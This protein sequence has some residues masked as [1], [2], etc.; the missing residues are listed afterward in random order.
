MHW[1]IYDTH[2]RHTRFEVKIILTVPVRPSKPV[3]SLSSP[4]VEGSPLT[5]TCVSTGGYPKQDVS[6]YRESVSPGNRLG[7]SVSFVNNTLYDVTSTL[8][9]TPTNQDDGVTYICQSSYNDD[10][11]LIQTSQH[12]ILLLCKF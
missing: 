11:R 10:S 6:W 9:F 2:K 3:I 8:M 4:A 7:G 1:S 5:L 12:Y